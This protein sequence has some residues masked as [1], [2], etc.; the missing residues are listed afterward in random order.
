MRFVFEGFLDDGGRAWSGDWRIA[1][2]D[3]E[4][5]P[6]AGD[7]F[8]LRKSGRTAGGGNAGETTNSAGRTKTSFGKTATS[9]P[10]E[11][12]ISGQAG[13]P[14]GQIG[15]EDAMLEKQGTYGSPNVEQELLDCNRL[16]IAGGSD[17][18]EYGR[19]PEKPV[20]VGNGGDILAGPQ[21]EQRFL[22]SL[23]GPNG[24][25]LSWKRQ[26]SGHGFSTTNSPLGWGVL[27]VYEVSHAGLGEPVLL[28]IN[29]Y[30]SDR[31]SAPAGFTIRAAK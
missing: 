8:S 20:M 5:Q 18:P 27:D 30:D 12:G 2:L 17:D 21:Y 7:S 24:E 13:V 31:L 28:Y 1:S 25:P 11:S 16:K 6:L 26:K 29:M 14:Q 4:E 3:D 22:N 10:P 9:K 23:A 15:G 19:S